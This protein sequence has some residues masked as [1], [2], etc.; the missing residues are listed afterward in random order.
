V[1]DIDPLFFFCS[2]DL[3]KSGRN[4]RNIIRY[5]EGEIRCLVSAGEMNQEVG[6]R[7]RRERVSTGP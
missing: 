7:R 5:W 2:N 3:E 4:K 6:R 1:N